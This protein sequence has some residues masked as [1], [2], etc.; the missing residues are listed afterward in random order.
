[1]IYQSPPMSTPSE[2]A[3]VPMGKAPLARRFFAYAID[4]IILS[5]VAGGLRLIPG[6]SGSLI[7]DIL[8]VAIPAIYFIWPY[9]TTGQTL[10]K[11]ALKIKVVSIDGSPLNWRKG[12][13]RSVGYLLSGAP[14]GLG[15]LW[16]IW[17]ADKQ[18]GHDKIAGTCVVPVSV[19][20]EQ[21]QG[22]VEPSEVRRKQRRWLVGLG[23]PALLIVI[24]VFTLIQR[25]VAEVTAMGPWPGAEVPPEE[26][27][28]VDLSHLG[29]RTGQILNAREQESWA[30][31]GYQEGVCI[32]YGSGGKTVAAIWALRYEDEETAGLDYRSIQAWSAQPGNCPANA[33]AYMGNS[34]MV[35]C[36]FIDAYVKT[37]W[38]D[39]W[40]VQIVAL[41][42]AG[43]PPNILVDQVRDALA[44]RWKAMAQPA[45]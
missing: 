45:P 36:Q 4:A 23:I 41:E 2:R 20:P 24:G 30:A 40:I 39:H 1:M 37:F 3:A 18:A 26:V 13:L 42:G 35:H 8:S 17:D 29:L 12:I 32:T 33:W 19:A 27:V 38:N 15:F 7:G 25:G 6:Y 21:L 16:A 22:T 44:A 11:L 10:G 31:A 9:S 28:A 14:L 34:G 43:F 5:L